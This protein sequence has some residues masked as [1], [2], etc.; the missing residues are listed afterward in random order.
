M[1]PF[2]CSVNCQLRCFFPVDILRNIPIKDIITFS[3]KL[4]YTIN[5]VLT[6]IYWF[7]VSCFNVKWQIFHAFSG[8][9]LEQASQWPLPSVWKAQ[10]LSRDYEIIVLYTGY[11]ATMSL[12]LFQIF[13]SSPSRRHLLYTT[14]GRSEHLYRL[15][16][17]YPV[18]LFNMFYSR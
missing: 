14:R 11:N 6:L 3:L 7:I 9:E 4:R 12:F 2:L 8:R 18:H 13:D 15:C 5:K 16:H 1:V 17:K 10:G